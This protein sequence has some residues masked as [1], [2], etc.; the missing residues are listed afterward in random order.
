MFLGIETRHV[1]F[2]LMFH[3]ILVSVYCE[4]EGFTS[5]FF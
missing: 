5:S 2:L 1:R 4:D 3:L